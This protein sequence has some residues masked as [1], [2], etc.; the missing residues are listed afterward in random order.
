MTDSIV[1]QPATVATT[2]LIDQPGKAPSRKVVAAGIGSAIGAVVTILALIGI[3]VPD[4]VADQV[5]TAIEA[6]A[7]AVPALVGWISAYYTRDRA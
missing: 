7:V 3:D 6:A 1:Y 4:D 2:V 5:T